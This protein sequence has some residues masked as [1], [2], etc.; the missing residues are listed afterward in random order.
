MI[1]TEKVKNRKIEKIKTFDENKFLKSDF[2]LIF[3]N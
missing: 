1:R 2:F 3:K